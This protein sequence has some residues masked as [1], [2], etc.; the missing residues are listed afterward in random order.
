MRIYPKKLNN[1]NELKR[2]KARLQGKLRDLEEEEFLSFGDILGAV[3]TAAPKGGMSSYFSAFSMLSPIIKMV[4]N[5]FASKKKEAASSSASTEQTEKK[6]STFGLK[7]VAVTF[8]SGYLKWKFGDITYKAVRNVVRSK[9]N[10]K[11]EPA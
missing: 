9:K 3:G 2:E 10:R 4:R 1:L 11:K 5:R 8:I 6:P 7:K